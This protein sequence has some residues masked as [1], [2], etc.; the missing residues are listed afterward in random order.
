MADAGNTPAD[1][2]LD[3]ATPW[4]GELRRRALADHL[5]ALSSDPAAELPAAAP[6]YDTAKDAPRRRCGHVARRP[7]RLA[8]SAASGAVP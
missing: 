7:S 4:P 6:L 1:E 3:D 8:A 5:N 2:V